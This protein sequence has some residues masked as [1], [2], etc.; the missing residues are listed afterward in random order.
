MATP[1][2]LTQPDPVNGAERILGTSGAPMQTQSVTSSTGATTRV[3]TSTTVATMKAVN[4]ARKGLTVFNES[5]ALLYVNLGSGAS[6]TNYTYAMPASAY[7]E[8]PYGYTGIVTA[9]LAT[10]SGN[11]QVTELT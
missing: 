3:A 5:T 10:G 4:A 6:A 9:T 7:Y 8:L 2:T 1:V 11:A